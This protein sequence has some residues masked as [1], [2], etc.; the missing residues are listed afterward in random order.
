ME[1]LDNG[2]VAAEQGRKLVLAAAAARRLHRLF[3]RAE[4]C[5]E[6][7]EAAQR[8]AEAAQ[9]QFTEALA[10]GFETAGIPFGPNDR[11]QVD[12]RQGHVTLEGE[13]HD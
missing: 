2:Q 10:E 7:A 8:T 1:A 11:Y 13:I 5:A 4:V 12:W 9:R 6:L 3:V